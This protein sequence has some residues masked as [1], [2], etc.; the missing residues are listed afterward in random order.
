MIITTT[1]SIE[2]R[3]IVS[4]EDVVFGEVIS[5]I[6][7]MK[8]IGAGMRNFFGGRSQGYEEEIV[9][10]RDQALNEMENR[11]LQLGADAV[12]GVKMDYETLGADNGM[13]MVTCSGTAVKLN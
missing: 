8:D 6:N 1:S 3:T 12:I 13:I 11:A 2:G 4:Y 7:F 5:G 10:A 9:V